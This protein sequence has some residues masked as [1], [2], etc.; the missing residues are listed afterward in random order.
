MQGAVVVVQAAFVVMYNKHWEVQS[1]L[2][3]WRVLLAGLL[4]R[5]TARALCGTGP[6]IQAPAAPPQ[7]AP[8]GAVQP[9]QREAAGAEGDAGAPRVADAEGAA[10]EDGGAA[11]GPVAAFAVLPVAPVASTYGVAVTAPR[12]LGQVHE[13]CL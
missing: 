8:P 1:V 3:G 13:N 5:E 11:D 2:V 9:T 10:R 6:L 7:A 12:Q 4:A